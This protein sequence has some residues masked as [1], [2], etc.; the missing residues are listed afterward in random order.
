M[1]PMAPKHRYCCWSAVSAQLCWWAVGPVRHNQ[2]RPEVAAPNAD[3]IRR[4]DQVPA[5]E[6]SSL[7]AAA[8]SGPLIG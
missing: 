3:S 4:D 8:V 5:A 6:V 1:F 2:P 7:K